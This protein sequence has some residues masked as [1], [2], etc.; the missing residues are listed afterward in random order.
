MAEVFNRDEPGFRKLEQRILL[1]EK[2]RTDGGLQIFSGSRNGRDGLEIRYV[3]VQCARTD[4][5]P[6]QPV[7]SK[8]LRCPDCEPNELEEDRI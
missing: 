3:C 8:N 1:I 4:Y 6:H 5:F 2:A 7:A